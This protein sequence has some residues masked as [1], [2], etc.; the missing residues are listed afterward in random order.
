[1]HA[2]IKNL[3]LLKKGVKQ[4]IKCDGQPP[5]WSTSSPSQSRVRWWRYRAT[6][7]WK[8]GLSIIIGVDI[9]WLWIKRIWCPSNTQPFALSKGHSLKLA[10]NLLGNAPKPREFHGDIYPHLGMQIGIQFSEA[11]D[12]KI[13]K[14]ET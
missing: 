4:Q 8:G 5:S 6:K 7:F 9:P 3:K 2:P 1:M 14:I 11:F 12:Q 10:F 13:I